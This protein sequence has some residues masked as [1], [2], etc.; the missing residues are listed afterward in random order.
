MTRIIARLRLVL[1]YSVLLIVLLITLLLTWLRWESGLPRDDWYAERKG[2]IERAAVES[3]TTPHGQ[4]SESVELVSDSGLEVSFRVVRSADNRAPLPVLLVLGGHRTGSDAVDL[5]GDVGDLAVVGVNYPY[6]GPE[7][8]RGAAQIAESIPQVRKAFLDT[9]PAVFLILDWLLEQ[10]WVDETRI[11]AVGASLGVPFAAA[12]G[13]R[14]SRIT[15]LMLVHGAADNR[16]WIEVNVAR[17]VDT[18]MLHYPL[19]TVLHWIAYGPL[20][21]TRQHVANVSPRPV[22]IVGARNDERTPANQTQLLFDAAQEPKQLRWTE[23]RH[24]Q[25]GRTEIIV[26]LLRI[27]NEELP[28]LTR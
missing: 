27:A 14:D 9:I 8:V 19:A 21:D 26:E 25:P 15:G 22:I 28:F 12:A 5:F 7:K 10:P 18:E 20:L 4:V 17:R 16:L 13:A 1:V 23:G 2:R 3:S 24:V 11:V 6:D